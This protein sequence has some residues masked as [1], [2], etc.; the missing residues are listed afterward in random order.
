[1]NSFQYPMETILN[2]RKEKEEIVKQQFSQ[3]Q[4]QYFLEEKFLK[5]LEEKLENV[6]KAYLHGEKR[7]IDSIEL[8]NIQQYI[9]FLRK[10]IDVQKQIV[11]K[12]QEKLEQKHQQVLF[13]QR[14]RKI[15]EKHKEKALEK[16]KLE[17]NYHEQKIIDEL[18]L[19]TCRKNKWMI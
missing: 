11:V 17:L 14:D 6:I 13:A 7:L 16:Y 2:Y 1:M 3:I 19:Y 12:I 10:K 5:N 8:K 18:A 15:I 9:N 4:K